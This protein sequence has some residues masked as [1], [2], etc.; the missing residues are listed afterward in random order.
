[1]RSARGH[2]EVRC[3]NCEVSFAA[4]TKNCI[5][6]GARTHAAVETGAPIIKPGEFGFEGSDAQIG[7]GQAVEPESDP[8]ESMLRRSTF[9]RAS[10][11]SEDEGQFVGDD[12]AEYSGEDEPP[13]PGRS[14][15]SSFGSLIWIGML[16]L[17]SIF[18]RNCGGD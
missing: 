1:M 7:G 4:G 5:H 12:A 15:L 16:V 13:T 18:G 3:S 9:G 10:T 6:C 2:F 8:L 11:S 17:Y 14:I